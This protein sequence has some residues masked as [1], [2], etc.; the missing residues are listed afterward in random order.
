[1]TEPRVSVVISAYNEAVSIVP[2]LDRV[3][4]AV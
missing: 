3:F 1:M 2:V 4:V